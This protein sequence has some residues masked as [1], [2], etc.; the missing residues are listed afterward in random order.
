VSMSVVTPSRCR[1]RPFVLRTFFLFLLIGLGMQSAA[2]QAPDS[3]AASV[4]MTAEEDH[5]RMMDLLGI[6][7]LRPGPSGN[8]DAPNAA[9]TDESRASTYTSLPDP[10]VLNDGRPVTT[11]EQWWQTRRAEIVEDFDREIY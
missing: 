3:S 5:Q 11:A 8:P 4:I 9:N 7:A 6:A 1:C 10:L 2:G